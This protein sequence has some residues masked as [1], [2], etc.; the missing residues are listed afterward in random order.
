MAAVLG[1]ALVLVLNV[2]ADQLST[3]LAPAPKTERVLILDKFVVEA[4][5]LTQDDRLIDSQAL[6]L[7]KIVDLSEVLSGELVE[8]SMVRKSGYGNEVNLRGFSQANLPVMVNGGFLEGACGSR[9]DPALSHLNLLMVDRLVVREGPYDVT[10]PGNLGG[11]ID[12]VTKQPE[13][14]F[15]GEVLA[16]MGSYDFR[17]V[18]A[19][20][21]GGNGQVQALAGYNFSKSGQYADGNGDR[22]WTVREDQSVPYNDLGQGMDTFRKHD[23]WGSLR[24]TPNARNTIQLDYA[25]GEADDILTPRVEFD[26]KRESTRLGRLNWILQGL[27]AASGKLSFSVYRNEV[28]HYPTQEFRAVA[29]PKNVVAQSDITGG[30]IQN[31]ASAQDTVWTYGL[32]MYRRTWRADVFNTATGALLN[33][34][35]VPSVEAVNLG[36]YVR[37]DRSV[38]PWQ[39]SAGVRLDHFRSQA[40]EALVQTWK[41][42]SENRQTDRLAGGY[43]SARYRPGERS[44]LFAGLGRSYR[45]PTGVE[46]YIQGSPTYFGNPTLDPT[47]NTEADLGYRVGSKQW[48][49]QIKGFY[50]DLKDYIYQEQT[51]TGYQTYANINAHIYGADAKASVTLGSGFSIDGGVAWQRGRKNRYPDN[52]TDRNLGQMAPLKSRLALDF[53]NPLALGR[54]HP[55]VF[56]MIEWV[57]A[58]A[59]RHV[60]TAAGEKALPGWDIANLRLGCR[61]AAWTAILGVDNLSDRAYAVANSYEWDV[62]G[63]SAAS[64]IIVNEPGRFAY[65]SLGYQW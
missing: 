34:Y 24:V 33:A 19:T 27:S 53:E 14:G 4:R 65:L 42:T 25:Y 11:S 50:S 18:G 9:K 63:G 40:D 12:V 22:L 64:P 39:L 36:G 43:V 45:M 21:T 55:V 28:G 7:H 49:F 58:N 16:R 37:W 31:V 44:Q 1:V 13:A 54:N 47:A 17:S 56:G 52:N 59:S 32:D 5:S 60:D 15:A 62:V 23:V 3:E 10:Q 57:H 61:F 30:S 26:T 46:R 41:T 29:V 51:I 48:S 20:A 38:G 2:S 35:L 6:R 8:A